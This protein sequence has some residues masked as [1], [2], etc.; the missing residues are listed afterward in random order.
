MRLSDSLLLILF[1]LGMGSAHAQPAALQPFRSEDN[2]FS[3]LYP[4]GWFIESSASQFVLPESV[5]ISNVPLDQRLTNPEALTIQVSFPRLWYDFSLMTGDTPREAVSQILQPLRNNI[6]PV[7]IVTPSASGTA[8]P[9]QI[10]QNALEIT[11]FSLGDRSGAYA[12]GSNTFGPLGFHQINF[13]LIMDV[14]GSN[15]V[16]V[17]ATAADEARVRRYE[18]DIVNIALSMR[19]DPPPPRYSGN[20]AL[21][22]VYT[23]PIGLWQRGDIE[24]FYPE[25]WFV[26][27]SLLLLI[28]NV[29]TH[30]MGQIRP[31]PGQVVAALNGPAEARAAVDVTELGRLCDQGTSTWTARELVSQL[32]SKVSSAIGNQL[33]GQGV[34]L[35]QPEVRVVNNVEIVYYRM[36][37]TDYEA[38]DMYID[39]G[40]GNIPQ[41]T[42][43]AR[44]GELASFEAILFEIASTFRY[45]P[46]P[47]EQPTPAGESA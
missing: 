8:Q 1:L 42:T 23:G 4:Q 12:Y 5:S 45:T 19:Y 40:N 17:T 33:Q 21:P 6:A 27:T 31:E 38:L 22:R 32:L 29:P 13:A 47:C 15:W 25:N 24:F 46:K 14:G 28:S 35:T 44:P 36:I 9:I 3:F 7:I 37:G 11:D 20:P 30:G 10:D 26:T 43:V 34:V 41:M 18:S 16:I 39:L 2:R